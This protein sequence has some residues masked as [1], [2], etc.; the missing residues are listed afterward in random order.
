MDD[1]SDIS[2]DKVMEKHD[3]DIHKWDPND[4][5]HHNSLLRLVYE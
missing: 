1:I 4:L 5:E 3:W 2:L